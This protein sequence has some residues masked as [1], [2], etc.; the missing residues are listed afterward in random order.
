MQLD[1]PVHDFLFTR[2]WLVARTQILARTKTD[3]VF[4]G[5]HERQARPGSD[6]DYR[7]LA[8]GRRHITTPGCV[9]A[10]HFAQRVTSVN[11][12]YIVSAR[13]L[14]GRSGTQDIDVALEGL[15]VG[16][17]DCQHC[18]IHRQATVRTHR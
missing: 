16:C 13:N 14:Q 12:V 17:I 2:H 4:I 6:I 8:A 10:Y 7:R 3:R 18:L 9:L 5:R 15:R 1:N 11:P